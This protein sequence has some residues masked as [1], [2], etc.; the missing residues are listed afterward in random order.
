M[1]F[2]YLE[3]LDSYDS[4]AHGLLFYGPK[5]SEKK[6]AALKLSAKLL[7]GSVANNPD[8]HLIE[9][10]DGKDLKIDQV[11]GLIY[12][13]CLKP[14]QS[15][16][17]VAIIDSAHKLNRVAQNSLLKLLE[18]PKGSSFLILITEYPGELLETVL[19][20]LQKVRFRGVNLAVSEKDKKDLIELISADLAYRFNWVKKLIDSEENVLEILDSWTVLLRK[21]LLAKV[22]GSDDGFKYTISALRDRIRSVQDTR[23]ILASTNAN[24]RLA[25]E[26]LL[27]NF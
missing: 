4:L 18:E 22:N 10:I 27:L 3:K 19:S 20:R 12:D 16:S 7:D 11:R 14:Y 17:K 23:K 13:L 2:E 1:N 6:E 5:G 21:S 8:F 25:L 9:P 26:A 15:K 24:K